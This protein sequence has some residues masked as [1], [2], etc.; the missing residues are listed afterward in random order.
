MTEIVIQ[1]HKLSKIFGGLT[2]VDKVDLTVPEKAIASIIGPNGAGKT[3]LFNCVSGFYAPEEGDVL[4]Y[5][6]PIQGQATD[7]ICSLGISRTYQNIRLFSQMTAVENILVGQHPRLKGTWWEAVLHNPRY[8]QEEEKAVGEA[9][10][11]LEFVGLD[12]LGDHLARNLPYG[13]QRRLE[14]A[15]ALANHPKLLM[16]DEPTAGMNSQETADMTAFIKSLRDNLGI[17]ILLIEHDMKVVM[18]IS[19]Q[20]TVLD[21]GTK[22]AEGL[23][24]EIQTNQQVIEAYLG[25]GAAALSK[26]FQRK[27]THDA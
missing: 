18:D 27:K 21:Y 19:D 9:L 26:K 11:L 13:A 3:T 2:A 1:T 12:G 17:T 6:K 25:P 16:L 15:R 7:R 20:I 10:H 22:I 4:F 14:I 8:M 24:K 5:G 23:P